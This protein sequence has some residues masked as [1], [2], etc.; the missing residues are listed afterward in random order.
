MFDNQALVQHI[1]V[2]GK[3]L[4]RVE[5]HV[6]SGR[7]ISADPVHE[8][9]LKEQVREGAALVS[10]AVLRRVI[11]TRFW[12]MYSSS[13]NLLMRNFYYFECLKMGSLETHTPDMKTTKTSWG[14]RKRNF[15]NIPLQLMINRCGKIIIHVQSM[16]KWYRWT[17][18]EE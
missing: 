1:N 17:A 14:K 7:A 4:Q 8:P 5:E 3:V 9:N 6:S 12:C 2:A 15:E 11:I 13:L 10:R 18:T 16:I